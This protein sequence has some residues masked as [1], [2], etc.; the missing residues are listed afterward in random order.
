MSIVVESLPEKLRGNL[1]TIEESE[2]ELDQGPS[3]IGP[4]QPL[5]I[6]LAPTLSCRSRIPPQAHRTDG[7]AQR[8]IPMAFWHSSVAIPSTE[9]GLAEALRTKALLT[10]M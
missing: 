3:R 1:P 9:R 5:Q 10:S 2:N 8:S 4:V 6:N 7:F